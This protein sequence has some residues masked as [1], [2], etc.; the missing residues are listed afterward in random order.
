MDSRTIPPFT[1]TEHW[2]VNSAL[3]ERYGHAVEV[4][5]VETEIRLHPDDRELALCPALY[6]EAR[7][8]KFVLSKTG[9]GRFRSMFFYRVRDRFGTGREEYDDIGDCV[10]MLLKIQADEEGRRALEQA[11]DT[12]PH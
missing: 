12:Q 3:K 2:V 6:W 7:G 10:M 4:Q 1:D 11:D 5:D 8:C 9:D